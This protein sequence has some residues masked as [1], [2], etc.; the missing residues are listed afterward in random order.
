MYITMPYDT[1]YMTNILEIASSIEFSLTTL[2]FD[3]Y[4]TFVLTIAN[5]N[6]AALVQVMDWRQTFSMLFTYVFMCCQVFIR[7]ISKC[8]KHPRTIQWTSAIIHL[9]RHWMLM[10]YIK[11]KNTIRNRKIY[12][13]VYSFKDSYYLL[14]DRDAHDVCFVST[15]I[16][17][18]FV[19][20]I[21]N[22]Y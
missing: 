16:N 21:C 2:C 18:C 12:K 15:M 1:A 14:D 17:A 7:W 3:S 4:F 9:N 19:C 22:G 5:D 10:F 8:T 13:F 6:T 11:I 20:S